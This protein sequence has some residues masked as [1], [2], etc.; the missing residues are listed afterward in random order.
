MAVGWIWPKS[1]WQCSLASVWTVGCQI[2][3]AWGAKW[4][5]GNAAAMTPRRRL[6]GD[7]ARPRRARPWNGSTRHNHCGEPLVAARSLGRWCVG[8]VRVRQGDALQRYAPVRPQPPALLPVLWRLHSRVAVPLLAG[9]PQWH[10][11][12]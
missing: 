12:V 6:I 11:V 2:Y 1:S 7:L 3:R 9:Q 4:R 10:G 8:S 5:P